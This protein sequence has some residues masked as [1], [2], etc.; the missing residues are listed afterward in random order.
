[1]EAVLQ[2]AKELGATPSA[3]ALAWAMARPQMTSVI[4]GARSVEQVEDNARAASLR[5]PAGAAA[6][7][8]DASAFALGHP[9]EM[10]SSRQGGW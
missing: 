8:D 7:L 3:V 5:L 1:L 6:Q 2:V 9:Y 4:F 10:L